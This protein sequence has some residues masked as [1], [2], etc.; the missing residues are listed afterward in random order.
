M[1]VIEL[2]GRG[3]Q[4]PLVDMELDMLESLFGCLLLR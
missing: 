1:V 3:T 2:V 4:W